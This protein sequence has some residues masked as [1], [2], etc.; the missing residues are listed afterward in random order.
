[1]K[2]V[3]NEIKVKELLYLTGGNTKIIIYNI[4]EDSYKLLWSGIVDEINFESVPYGE[5]EI[6]HITVINGEDI[7][8]IHIEEGEINERMS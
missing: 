2:D 6:K 3:M 7:L 4:K 5:S 8:Q 1:M